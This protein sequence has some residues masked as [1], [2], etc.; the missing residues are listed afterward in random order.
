MKYD[1]IGLLIG[2]KCTAACEICCFSSNMDCTEKLD[3]DVVKRYIYSAKELPFIKSMGFSGGEAFL[4]YDDLIEYIKCVKAIGKNATVTTNGFWAS[5]GDSAREKL[6]ELK[7][8]GLDLLGVSYDEFHAKYIPAQN[9]INIIIQSTEVGIPLK[10]QGCMLNDSKV[11]N[12]MEGL[13]FYIIGRDFNFF[14][15]YPTGAAEKN[16]SESR[17]VRENPIMNGVCRKDRAC[18]IRFD[19]S[20]FPCCKILVN[21]TELSVGNIYDEGMDAAKTMEALRGNNILYVLRN[22]GF[23][24][25][26]ETARTELS[27]ELPERVIDFCELCKLFFCKE[28][29][30]KF[31]P[32]VHKKIR[33]IKDARFTAV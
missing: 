33:E 2:R 27:M 11:G 17:F 10:I 31:I 1:H 22:Y 7:A 28:N 32:Y 13:G 20:I 18:S 26:V 4:Y 25:F 24:F 23:N 29:I 9:I 12:W 6:L 5:D 15:C 8:A 30:H 16:I 3:P 19:G 21:D 14:P